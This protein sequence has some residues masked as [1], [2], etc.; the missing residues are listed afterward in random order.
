MKKKISTASTYA[1]IAIGAGLSYW[2][3]RKRA[4]EKFATTVED[5]VNYMRGEN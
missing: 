5:Y 3:T 1:A 2:Y 4:E